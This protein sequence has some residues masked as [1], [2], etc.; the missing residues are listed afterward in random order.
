VW[1][2]VLA[3]Y[4]LTRRRTAAGGVVLDL[5]CRPTDAAEVVREPGV[6]PAE[7]WPFVS[8]KVN[9]E[10]DFGALIIAPDRAWFSLRRIVTGGEARNR[11]IRLALSAP[12]T[13]ARFILH[14]QALDMEAQRWTPDRGPYS[15]DG[16]PIVGRHIELCPSY[17]PD[18]LDHVSSW[19][20]ADRRDTWGQVASDD[21]SDV[22]A[23]EI[24]VTLAL[25]MFKT[26]GKGIR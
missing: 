1:I 2:S 10:P 8:S 24:N 13:S 14:G 21:T 12:G 15:R 9:A 18:G 23:V 6:I 22:W 5:G 20:M 26:L 11:D 25:A 17:G 4:W 19:G 3:G 16:R 7:A